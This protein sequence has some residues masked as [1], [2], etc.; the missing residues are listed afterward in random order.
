MILFRRFNLSVWRTKPAQLFDFILWWIIKLAWEPFV[1]HYSQAWHWVKRILPFNSKPLTVEN[2]R[3]D[4]ER[5]TNW[6]N[7]WLTHFGW[8]KVVLV[9]PYIVQSDGTINIYTGS[10]QIGWNQP[11]NLK[12]KD[13]EFEM[14]TIIQ[15]GIISLLVGPGKTNFFAHDLSG[16]PLRLSFCEFTTKSKAVR[17]GFRVY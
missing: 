15:Y 8:R 3:N 6:K 1:L 13:N 4:Q 9:A 11:G 7:F 10:Y 5:D 14:C 12:F 17:R 16:S 2:N